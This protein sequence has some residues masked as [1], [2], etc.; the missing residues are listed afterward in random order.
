MGQQLRR[1]R[2]QRSKQGRNWRPQL[3]ALIVLLLS[4]SMCFAVNTGKVARAHRNSRTSPELEQ[5]VAATQNTPLATEK[6]QVIV[7]FRTRST[8][9]TPLITDRKSTRLNSSHQIISYA[10]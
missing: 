5:L 3:A 2:W 7:Q 8:Q 6:L 4:A 1:N 10:V 9:S